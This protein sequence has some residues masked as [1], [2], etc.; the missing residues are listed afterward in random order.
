M[1]AVILSEDSL[2]SQM[3]RLELSEMGFKAQIKSLLTFQ[4]MHTLLIADADTAGKDIIYKTN[5][6]SDAVIIFSKRPLYEITSKAPSETEKTNNYV[7][8]QRPFSIMLFRKTVCKLTDKI[9]QGRIEIDEAEKCIHFRGESTILTEQEFRLFQL[10][11][12]NQGVPVSR[13]E[14]FY[15]LYNGRT[16]VRKSNIVDVYIRFL[17]EKLEAVFGNPM[18]VTVR[19][20]GYMLS[21]KL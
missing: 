4:D 11:V 19:G 21:D 18:I 8:L 17:R 10:L 3:L 12:Q 6:F 13:E 15:A 5:E 14:A 2:Y 16:S 20:K 1:N 9:K 7:F